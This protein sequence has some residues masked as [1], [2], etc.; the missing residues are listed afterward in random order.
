MPRPLNTSRARHH[1]LPSSIHPLPFQYHPIRNPK[2]PI[3]NTTPITT[4][5]P[6]Q[7]QPQLS[8]IT[9]AIINI[10]IPIAH[11]PTDT[12]T[13]VTNKSPN[14]PQLQS[15]KTDQYVPYPL[16]YK[17]LV[18]ANTPEINMPPNSQNHPSATTDNNTD[19]TPNK[20]NPLPPLNRI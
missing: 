8:S 13:I 10:P 11:L 2:N 14:T 16:N 7:S 9:T 6:I 5:R 1:L 17:N 20:N 4:Y 19:T 15:A 3:V 12:R 18:I